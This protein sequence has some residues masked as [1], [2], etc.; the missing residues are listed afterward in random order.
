M[1]ASDDSLFLVLPVP[2][3]RIGGLLHA[4][5]QAVHGLGRWADNFP[6]VVAAMVRYPEA[7]AEK[8]RALAWEPVDGRPGLERVEILDLPFGYGL[9]AHFRH[10]P[11]I[12]RRLQERIETARYLCF[13]VGGCLGDWGA[14]AASLS[15]RRGRPFAVWAD[16]VEPRVIQQQALAK[17]SWLRRWKGLAYAELV[18]RYERRVIAQAALGLFNG[19]D[20]YETYKGCLARAFPVMDIHLAA[21]DR[22]PAAEIMA[23]KGSRRLRIGYAGRAADM[24]APL[25]W[26]AVLQELAGMGVDFEAVWLGDGP[27]LAAMRERVEAAGLGGRVSLPGFVGER[28]SVLAAIRGWD[29]LLFTHVTPESPRILL[30]ALVSAT[31]IV[32]YESLYARDLV[33]DFGADYLVPVG[34]TATLASRLARL[35]GDRAELRRLQSASHAGSAGFNDVAVFR[36]RSELIKTYL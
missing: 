10:L 35:A 8:L 7:V 30:E 28:A 25:Q 13:A 14:V 3:R 23:R 31:P 18:R 17:T 32:G 26:L 1:T 29:V 11:E 15:H 9:P 22:L 27:L 33:Q 6:R 20:T 21:A 34:A 19:R 5:A 12:R 24:K 36:R 16:R 4:E 2:L